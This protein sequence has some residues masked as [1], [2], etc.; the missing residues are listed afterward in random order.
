MI[1]DYIKEKSNISP[2]DIFIIINKKEITYHDFDKHVYSIEQF[3]LSKKKSLNC[4]IINCLDKFNLLAS[5]IAC[6]R[7]NV[8]PAVFPPKNNLIK[9]ADYDKLIKADLEINDLSCMMQ[10]I[11]RDCRESIFYNET[12]IQCVLFT[13][14]TE[15]APKAVQ[16]T[17][18]NI[19][20]SAVN[21]DNVVRFDSDDNY[22]NILPLWHIAGLSIFFRSIYFNFKSIIY[23]YDKNQIHILIKKYKINCISIVPKMIRDLNM[24]NDELKNFKIVIVGGDNISINDYNFFNKNQINAYISYGMT[25]TSSGIAGYFITKI[26]DYIDGYIGTPHQNTIIKIVTKTPKP[27]QIKDRTAQILN[28]EIKLIFEF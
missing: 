23:N 19:Y 6:N 13:S 28:L 1:K 16:L 5:I 11:G 2:K 4:I 3:V 27:I 21:W 7:L 26:N 8:R 10:P 24:Q 17:F 20:N 9:F 14:G 18:S 12:D 15:K 22:L 25:E